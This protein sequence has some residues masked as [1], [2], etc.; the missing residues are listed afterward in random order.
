MQASEAACSPRR[1]H[2]QLGTRLVIAQLR[3]ADGPDTLCFQ[4]LSPMYWHPV[5]AGGLLVYLQE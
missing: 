1:R 3:Q 5:G 4:Q 2:V